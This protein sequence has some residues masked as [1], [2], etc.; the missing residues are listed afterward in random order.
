MTLR[1]YTKLSFRLNHPLRYSKE[2]PDV[3]HVFLTYVT[4][5]SMPRVTH[6]SPPRYSSCV[7]CV[8]V[9]CVSCATQIL[10]HCPLRYLSLQ[11]GGALRAKSAHRLEYVDHTLVLH[12]LQHSGQSYEHPC[13]THTRTAKPQ[14][15]LYT[16]NITRDRNRAVSKY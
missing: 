1:Q 6:T 11:H 4:Q 12:T 10:S 3:T 2:V 7:L 14:V 13:A 8:T 15:Q 9:V 5:V 16:K